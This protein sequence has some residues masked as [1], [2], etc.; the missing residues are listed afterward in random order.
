MVFSYSLFIKKPLDNYVK[1]IFTI[2][3]NAQL[4]IELKET[5]TELIYLRRIAYDPQKTSLLS[6]ENYL[7]Q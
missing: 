6:I 5:Q 1:A 7:T 3:N 2:K 4:Q